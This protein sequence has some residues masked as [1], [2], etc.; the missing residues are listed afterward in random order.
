VKKKNSETVASERQLALSLAESSHD[1]WEDVI[2]PWCERVVLDCWKRN[3]PAVIVVPTRGHANALKARLLARRLSYF[4]LYF[5]TPTGLREML[6]RD[7]ATPRGEPEHLRLLL[8]IAATEMSDD[9]TA[10]AVARSPGPLLRA[11]DRLQTAGWKFEELALTSFAP[12][13]RRFNELKK[14]CGFVLPGEL[15]RLR[16]QQAT[17]SARK[18]SAILIAGFDGAHWASWF[19]LRTA[20]ELAENATVVLEEPRSN[21]SEVDLCWIGSWE[22]IYGEAK[23][24]TK[25][26]HVA[27]DSLFSEAEMRGDTQEPTT[28]FDFLIG[29]NASE[30]AEAIARQCVRYLAE[31]NCTRLGV[32]FPGSG[33]LPRL[34][35]R[36]LARLDIPHND[37]LAHIVPGIFESAEWQAWLELQRAPRLNSFLRFLNSLPDPAVLSPKISRQSF[38]RILRESYSEVLLDDLEIL[39]AFCSA[40]TEEKFQAVAEALRALSF[41]PPRATLAQ[42]LE[43]THAALALLGWKQHALEIENVTRDWPQRLSVKFSRALFLRWLEETAATFGAARSPAGDHP[44][45]RVQLLT[46]THA[47][48]QEWSHLIFAG[49]NEGAWPPPA[50]AEFAREE[51]IRASNRSLQHLNKCA[52]RQGSQGEGHTAVRENHGLYLGPIEQRALALRQFEALLESASEGVTLA[53]SL[54]QEDAPER[55]WNPSECLTQ[56]YFKAR[57]EPLTQ[58]TL[59]NLQRATALLP[60][61]QPS[62]A[63]AQQTLIA[64]NARRDASNPAGEYDFALRPNDSYRPLPTLSVSDLEQ[65]VSSPAIVWMKRYLGVEAPDDTGNPW[66]AT[67]GKWVHRW[68]AAIGETRERKLFTAFP[69][70]TKIDERVRASA[71]ERRTTLQ[72]FCDSLG[73]IVPD[74]WISGWLNARYL[75][76]HL[77]AKIAGAEEWKWMAAEYPVGREAAVKIARDVELQLRGQIDLILAQDDTADF[78]GQKIWIVDYKTGS[79]KEVKDS[80]L[81]DSLVKGTTLQLGLYALALRARGA[82]EV[83]ASILSSAVRKVAPQLS[84]ADLAPH[85]NIFADLA[86]MQQSGVFGMKGELR[87]AFGYS[88]TYPLATLQIDEDVLEDKWQRTHENLVLEKEEWEKW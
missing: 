71:D 72:Q 45:A 4:G 10:K 80:D 37:G 11:L 40:R 21:L 69:T 6:S 77:G 2:A 51:E 86:A 85:T 28:R 16:L 79:T 33:A 68:L 82:A 67:S 3:L 59:K 36:A 42:F 62:N 65:M 9:L 32:I 41:L 1:A 50:S 7:D 38:D 39:R 25:T 70:S 87:P 35:A 18:F 34:V 88:A 14:Q 24:T 48:N 31:E 75:A 27:S 64:F 55:F 81:H 58:A 49:W 12:L 66:A 46:I 73:K 19:L 5:V 84:V 54:V 47:Q 22:E 60:N 43:Q 63:D 83:S 61:P 13:V 30:Q 57:R 8:A 56:L 17:K 78:A 20:V 44:Y 53:A 29:T 74:W 23:R 26:A 15:D 52:A 76:R